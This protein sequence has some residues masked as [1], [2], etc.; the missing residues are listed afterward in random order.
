MLKNHSWK[1]IWLLQISNTYL[2]KGDQNQY[3]IIEPLFGVINV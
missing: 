2:V 1:V 3:K